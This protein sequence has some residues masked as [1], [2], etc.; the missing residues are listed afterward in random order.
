MRRYE[1][2]R[3]SELVHAD[4][5]KLRKSP[6]AAAIMTPAWLRGRSRRWLGLRHIGTGCGHG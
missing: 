6:T 1:R 2:D 5:K 3:P 4:I